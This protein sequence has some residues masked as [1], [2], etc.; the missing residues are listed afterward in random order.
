MQK[1]ELAQAS[2]A[3]QVGLIMT[4]AKSER[5]TKERADQR[6]AQ[7]LNARFEH[8]DQRIGHDIQYVYER[9]DKDDKKHTDEIKGL[10]L[11]LSGI[12]LKIDEKLEELYKMLW[13][14]ALSMT[15]LGASLSSILQTLTK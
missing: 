15:V 7:E 4:R 6:A 3:E 13:K 10:R 11:D 8:V 5:G 2:T 9:I 12:N 1:L 14:I